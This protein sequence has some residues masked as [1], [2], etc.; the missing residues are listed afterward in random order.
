M[1]CTATAT[2]M[3]I[4]QA[5]IGSTLPLHWRC[6]FWKYLVHA[7]LHFT[8]SD[9]RARHSAFC[10]SHPVPACENHFKGPSSKLSSWN[11]LAKIL[12]KISFNFKFGN[13]CG[14][15]RSV[16]PTQSQPVKTTSKAR[17]H[18]ET[19]SPEGCWRQICKMPI[20][21]RESKYISPGVWLLS[22]PVSACENHFKGRQAPPQNFLRKL[23]R[24][25]VAEDQSVINVQRSRCV[26]W[27]K[28]VIFCENCLQWEKQPNKQS[29][30]Q[31]QNLE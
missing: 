24:P 8:L 2:E 12:L 15:L 30:K 5:A 17:P 6:P 23:A 21:D 19:S 22:V 9:K 3:N 26:R 10:Q 20:D 13:K 27:G 1:P 16:S 18:A 14:C 25:N 29:K 11:Q 7:N 4:F 28:N 31:K